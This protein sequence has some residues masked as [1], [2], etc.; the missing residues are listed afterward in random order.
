MFKNHSGSL[1]LCMHP[2]HNQNTTTS[3]QLTLNKSL[4]SKRQHLNGR[5][6]AS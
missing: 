2:E 5:T 6:V 1:I 3:L 4:Y